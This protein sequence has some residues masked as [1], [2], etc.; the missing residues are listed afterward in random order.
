MRTESK[1]S[2]QGEDDIGDCMSVTCVQTAR[3]AEQC[4][5]WRQGQLAGDGDRDLDSRLMADIKH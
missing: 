1:P 4:L 2:E 5:V 3:E